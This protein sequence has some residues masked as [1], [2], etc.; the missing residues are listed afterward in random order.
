[1][2]FH[3]MV[4]GKFANY[5]NSTILFGSMRFSDI[6]LILID[7]LH[8]MQLFYLFLYSSNSFSIYKLH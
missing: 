1:M 2:E 5:D 8:S 6:S 3:S 7:I 4:I